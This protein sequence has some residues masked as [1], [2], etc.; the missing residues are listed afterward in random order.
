MYFF[1]SWLDFGETLPLITRAGEVDYNNNNKLELSFAFA[2][3]EP[4]KAMD[5]DTPSPFGQVL[6]PDI[7]LELL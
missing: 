5:S 6:A 4:A 3:F 7:P 2:N 1:L